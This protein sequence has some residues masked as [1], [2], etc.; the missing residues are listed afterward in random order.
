MGP[1]AKEDESSDDRHQIAEKMLCQSAISRTE[2]YRRGERV[3]KLVNM[4]VEAGV[5]EQ[6][7]LFGYLHI[8]LGV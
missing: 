5:V 2:C 8:S 3:V 4:L 6:P 1:L 7:V